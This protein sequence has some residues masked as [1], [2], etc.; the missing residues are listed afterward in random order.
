MPSCRPASR[1]SAI[2]L[3]WAGVKSTD[4]SMRSQAKGLRMVGAN[5]TAGSIS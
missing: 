3:R 1:L 5:T 2:I 4:S